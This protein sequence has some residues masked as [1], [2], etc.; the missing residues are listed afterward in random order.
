MVLVDR[1]VFVACILVGFGLPLF[2]GKLV[3]M[4]HWGTPEAG[5]AWR[6][7]PKYEEMLDRIRA[8]PDNGKMLTLPLTDAF[9]Q[10]LYGT[11]DTCPFPSDQ[12]NADPVGASLHPSILHM[13]E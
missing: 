8:L 7:D 1:R 3:N 2:Q 4:T 12:Y 6:M 10:V 11:N 9:H 5:V 13:Q